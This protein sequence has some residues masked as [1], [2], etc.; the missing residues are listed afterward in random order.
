MVKY[1]RI[2]LPNEASCLSTFYINAGKT[3]YLIGNFQDMKK[4]FLLAE[5]IIKNFDSYW[6]NSVLNAFLA[7]DA[8]LENDN[9]KVIHYLKCAISEG[10]IINN[11]T[12]DRKASC[13]ERV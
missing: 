7:L 3:S 5:K 10:K 12:T 4:F 8:F 9:L 11:P 2:C 6:K 13:R 1:E